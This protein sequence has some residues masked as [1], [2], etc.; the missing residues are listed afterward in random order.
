MGNRILIGPI[1]L[2]VTLTL[3]IASARAHDE[4]K[5]P[6]WSG[7]W[8]RIGGIQFDPSKP[9]G[10]GQQAPLTPEYQDLFE[11]GLA[12]LA[13]GGHG[14]NAH[15]SCVPHGMPRMMNVIYPMEFIIMPDITYI[16]FEDNLPRRIH[17]DG[18]DWPAELEPSFAGYS[19][20]RWLDPGVA[21]RYDLLE[22]ETRHMK[23]PRTFEASGLPLHADNQTVVK[24]RIHL[25]NG[26]PDVLHDEIT[27]IDHALTRPWTVTKSYRR[28]RNPR[29]F[30]NECAED[31]HHI[32][33]GKDDY[34]I[35][36]D[37]LLMPAMKDQS[38]PDLRYFHQSGK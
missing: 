30:P 8:F 10:R 2:A 12:D 9:L 33:I 3:A 37:G 4:S 15:T 13:A 21:G 26:R 7:Q 36:A 22:V 23:G 31:N 18:R 11:K 27:T 32:T 20:G 16:L 19:I 1:A 14:L 38:T 28:E 6:D 25:D 24:E 35:G 34:F 5:Y 29:W 17:T